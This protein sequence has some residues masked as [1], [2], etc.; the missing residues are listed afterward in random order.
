MFGLL[1]P[2][3][4][5]SFFFLL[6]PVMFGMKREESEKVGTSKALAGCLVVFHF[7]VD[8]HLT[9]SLPAVEYSSGGFLV[10]LMILIA[11]FRAFDSLNISGPAKLL[12]VRWVAAAMALTYALFIVWSFFILDHI[13]DRQN[14]L[15]VELVGVI[16]FIIVATRRSVLFLCVSLIV[17]STTM[18][19]VGSPIVG[20]LRDVRNG[21]TYQVKPDSVPSE[22]V[23]ALP[24]LPGS[25]GTSS[26]TSDK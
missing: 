7:I 13:P 9:G 11:L 10:D 4:L 19:V 26:Q 12:N 20:S 18:V 3:V 17:M 8:F 25:S 6:L 2:A 22:T 21:A 5:G 1:Y 14:L 24:P 16:L 23:E 15:I